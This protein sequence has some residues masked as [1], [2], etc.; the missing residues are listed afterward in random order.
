MTISLLFLLTCIMVKA[1]NTGTI[2]GTIVTNEGTPIEMVSISIKITAKEITL[3]RT[4]SLQL[5]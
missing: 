1:Q 4:V 3:T 2:T 5:K